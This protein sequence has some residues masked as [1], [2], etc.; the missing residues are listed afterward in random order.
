MS[1]VTEAGEVDT[2]TW[3]AL[4][5]AGRVLHIFADDLRTD[6]DIIGKRALCGRRM[7]RIVHPSDGTMPICVPC[8]REEQR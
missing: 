3:Y 1:E 5:R 8:D 7:V 4:T 6:A 2:L